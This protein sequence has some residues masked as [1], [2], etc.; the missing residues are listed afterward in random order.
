MGRGIFAN[1]GSDGD[2]GCAICSS[3][4]ADPSRQPCHGPPSELADPLVQLRATAQRTAGGSPADTPLRHPPTR[5]SSACNLA[6]VSCSATT[7]IRRA[8]SRFTRPSSK[9]PPRSRVRASSRFSTSTVSCMIRRWGRGR[10]HAESSATAFLAQSPQL[11]K[12]MCIAGDME[13]VY[14]IAPGK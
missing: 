8:S 12:Q 10:T 7:S 6:S 11:A 9:A 13:R 5:P 14:E 2:R 4:P 3:Q 1:S